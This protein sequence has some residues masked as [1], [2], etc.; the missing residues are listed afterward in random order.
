MV[1]SNDYRFLTVEC[2]CHLCCIFFICFVFFSIIVLVCL[3]L[4]VVAVSTIDLVFV[5]KVVLPQ[6]LREPNPTDPLNNDAA[7]LMQKDE[8]LYGQKVK[9]TTFE[10]SPVLRHITMFLEKF[11]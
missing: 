7:D 2:K 10:F 11:K 3:A 5:F 4:T 9:G 1:M 8:E 6:L